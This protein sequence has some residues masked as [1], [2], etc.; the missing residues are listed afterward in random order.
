MKLR[1]FILLVVWIGSLS[2]RAQEP[3]LVPITSAN[4]FEIT[5]SGML[6]FGQLRDI[7]WSPSGNTIAVG[8]S[9]G[10]ILYDANL[11]DRAAQRRYPFADTTISLVAYSPDGRLLAAF[12]DPEASNGQPNIALMDTTNNQLVTRWSVDGDGSAILFSPDGITI[13]LQTGAQV[14]L[15][16][17]ASLPDVQKLKSD[18]WLHLQQRWYALREAPPLPVEQNAIRAYSSGGKVIAVANDAG[19]VDLWDAASATKRVTTIPSDRS[20][21]FSPNGRIIFWT[22]PGG[23]LTEVHIWDVERNEEA[24]AGAHALLSFTFHAFESKM[25]FATANGNLWVW[26]ARTRLQRIILGYEQQNASQTIFSVAF[27]P[28]TSVLAAARVNRIELWDTARAVKLAVAEVSPESRFTINRI[29]YSPDGKLI[30][31]ASTD[32]FVQ[33]RDARTLTLLTTIQ[34]DSEAYDLDFSP[35]SRLLATYSPVFDN[36]TNLGDSA[37]FIWRLST[38]VPNPEIMASKDAAAR[39]YHTNYSSALYRVRFSPDG[40]SIVFTGRGI[41]RWN[42]AGV[43]D[44]GLNADSQ[45]ELSESWVGVIDSGAGPLAWSPDGNYL[46]TGVSGPLGDQSCTFAIWDM[47]SDAAPLCAYGDPNGVTDLNYNPAGDTI[48]SVNGI[49]GDTSIQIWDAVSAVQLTYLYHLESVW[50]AVF[51]PNGTLL[52]SGSGCASCSSDGFS[53]DGTVRLWGISSDQR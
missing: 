1:L 36:D 4:A 14:A 40:R 33:I 30:A 51:S 44:R 38:I 10:L 12:Q 46:A 47:N 25:L 3:G 24:F 19:T 34:H 41:E 37:I 27:S 43:M 39:I 2:L 53:I 17:I 29:A 16:N 9:S 35:D 52:A 31:T 42:V 32:G 11:M 20:L 8:S 45:D 6:G 15:W 28:T 49:N 26:D 18:T 48:A 50:T 21:N 7:A 23:S 5:Q 13:G 22:A